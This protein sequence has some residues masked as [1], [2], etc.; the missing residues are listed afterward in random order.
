MRDLELSGLYT[1]IQPASLASSDPDLAYVF[2]L[3]SSFMYHTDE[4]VGLC[5]ATSTIAI[6]GSIIAVHLVHPPQVTA[7]AS[8][9][10]STVR[11]V[12]VFVRYVHSES[13]RT[14]HA[15]VLTCHH[16]EDTLLLLEYDQAD[17]SF[18]P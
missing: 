6:G 9:E 11:G 18:G 16:N 12:Y 2:L 7:V 13:P 10:A 14:H 17:Q 3:I 4:A 15:P 8:H 5:N 1:H